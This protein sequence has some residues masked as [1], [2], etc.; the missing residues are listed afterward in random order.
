[1]KSKLV[2]DKIPEII[3]DDGKI[4]RTHFADKKEFGGMLN[5]RF[6]EEAEEFIQIPSIEKMADIFE[7]ITA[8]NDFRGWKLEEVIKIQEKKREKKGAFRRRVI[9]DGIE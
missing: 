2:R 8:I 5:K 9:L 3:K 6:Q 1:M 4:P 7:V